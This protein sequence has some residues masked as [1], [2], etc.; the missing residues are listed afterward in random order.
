MSVPLP[1]IRLE[2][3]CSENWNRMSLAEQGRYCDTCT[4]VVKDFTG[5][6]DTELIHFL[7]TY[8]EQST[9][10][11]FREDQLIPSNYVITSEDKSGSFFRIRHFLQ[12]LLLPLLALFSFPQSGVAHTNSSGF[13]PSKPGPTIS[14]YHPRYIHRKK[15]TGRRRM[16]K[17]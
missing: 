11:R 2:N 10:G 3:P 8:K 6:S 1:L 15:I 13:H 4:T 7:Q 9:C 12:I 14:H 16:G 5:M 17:F